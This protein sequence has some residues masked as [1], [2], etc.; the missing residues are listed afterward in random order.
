[1]GLSHAVKLSFKIPEEPTEQKSKDLPKEPKEL[2]MLAIPVLDNVVVK[3]IDTLAEHLTK[4]NEREVEV[5]NDFDI[6]WVVQS[7][8]KF[9]KVSKKKP[10]KLVIMPGDK[11]EEEGS[12]QEGSEESEEEEDEGSEEEDEYA[13]D[14]DDEDKSGSGSGS[15]DGSERSRPKR[16]KEPQVKQ[17]G[18]KIAKGSS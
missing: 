16:S 13:S 17:A 2:S 1:M 7:M 4:L 10:K 15:E 9:S 5:V 8:C 11:E 3:D 18:F 12:E 14:H 6:P